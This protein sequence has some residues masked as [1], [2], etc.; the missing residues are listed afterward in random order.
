[1]DSATFPKSMIGL[2]PSLQPGRR[3][4]DAGELLSAF[5]SLFGS[6]NALVGSAT[7]PGPMLN[8]F[9]TFVNTAPGVNVSLPPALP[10][11]MLFVMSGPNNPGGLV[12]NAAVNNPANPSRPDAIINVGSWATFPSIDQADGEPDFYI[13]YELG[14]WIRIVL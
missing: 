9:M 7:P 14:T 4:V 12:V 3:I 11:R 1:M 5:Q 13:A 8:S 10:G 6:S 2:V